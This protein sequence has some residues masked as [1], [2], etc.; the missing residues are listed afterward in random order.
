[1]ET[2]EVENVRELPFLVAMR[3]EPE[4]VTESVLEVL[5][6]MIFS[7][8]LES[9]MSLEVGAVSPLIGLVGVE[10]ETELD[11]PPLPNQS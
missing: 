10:E 9:E 11:S 4:A 8:P 3:F 5:L 7:T 1:M 2:D 6:P